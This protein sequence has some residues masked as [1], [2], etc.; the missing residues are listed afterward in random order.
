MQML[1]TLFHNVFL[2][3]YNLQ[4]YQLRR[5]MQDSEM[6]PKAPLGNNARPVQSLHHRTVRTN[7]DF[8]RTKVGLRNQLQ[9]LQDY[10]GNT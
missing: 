3:F 10:T 8:K 6:T 7:I 1:C 2:L 4:L 9:K 5:L